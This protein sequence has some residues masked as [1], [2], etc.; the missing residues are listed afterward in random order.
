MNWNDGNVFFLA[1]FDDNMEGAVILPLIR[2]I[3]HQRTLR[4]AKID[5]H[6]NSHGGYAH[7]VFQLISLVEMAKRDGI[8]VRTIVPDTAY[9]AGS[10]L[11]ITGTPGERYI[12]RTAS[13]LIHY[14]TAGLSNETTPEQVERVYG[15]KSKHFA[16]IKKHYQSYTDIPSEEIDRLMNDDAAFIPANKAIQWGLADKYTDK[17]DIGYTHE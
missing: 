12:E 7:L 1:D 4:D 16:K 9:S 11:A 5:L 6:I 8:I 2:Q 3:Q 14:G 13:H 15:A 10:I 17:F